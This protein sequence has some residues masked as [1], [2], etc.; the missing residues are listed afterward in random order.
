MKK[1]AEFLKANAK[2]DLLSWDAHKKAMKEF[3]LTCRDIDEAAL[4]L[5][6][7][8]A[9]YQRNRKRSLPPFRESFFK[10]KLPSSDVEDWADTSSRNLPDW[11]SERSRPLTLI[12]LRN[13][14]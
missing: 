3:G 13:T 11:A 10:A 12:F 9:R 1:L 7:L 14:T 2:G 4:A 5:D 6:I 8:P